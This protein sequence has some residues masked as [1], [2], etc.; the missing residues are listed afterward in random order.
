MSSSNEKKTDTETKTE[1]KE[2]DEKKEPEKTAESETKKAEA[3]KTDSSIFNKDNTRIVEIKI[4]LKS[5]TD[6]FEINIDKI[7]RTV[8]FEIHSWESYNMLA[9]DFIEIKNYHE[10]KTEKKWFSSKNSITP[11]DVLEISDKYIYGSNG[12]AY[13]ITKCVQKDDSPFMK[14]NI[15]VKNDQITLFKHKFKLSEV[16]EL[17]S[18]IEEIVHFMK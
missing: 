15:D 12:T 16:L 6:I 18:V 14:Y 3:E 9:K 13:P 11:I 5:Q 1:K 10:T 4:D 17:I 7:S 2:A 8:Y